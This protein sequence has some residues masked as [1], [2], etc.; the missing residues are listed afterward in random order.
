MSEIIEQSKYHLIDVYLDNG[1]IL[2]NHKVKTEYPARF[3]SAVFRHF[4]ANDYFFHGEFYY[5]TSKVYMVKYKGIDVKRYEE[6]MEKNN[7]KE[8]IKV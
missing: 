8:E 6:E 5:V 3:Q 2:K 7:D 1:M 4:F